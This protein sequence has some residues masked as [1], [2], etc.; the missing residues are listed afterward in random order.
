MFIFVDTISLHRYLSLSLS[1]FGW[2]CHCRSAINK[3]LYIQD[4]IWYV[5]IF[6]LLLQIFQLPNIC[7]AHTHTERKKEKGRGETRHNFS[8]SALL[9]FFFSLFFPFSRFFRLFFVFVLFAAL[10]K[11][12]FWASRCEAAVLFNTLSMGKS[13]GY[14]RPLHSVEALQKRLNINNLFFYNNNFFFPFKNV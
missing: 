5:Y 8:S 4:D 7:L 9:L 1:L 2:M 14:S 6:C 12:D 3:Q 10:E 13:M 11:L